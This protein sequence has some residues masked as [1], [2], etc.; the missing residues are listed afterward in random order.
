MGFPPVPPMIK[1]I[2]HILKV[3]DEHDSRD[4]VVS[5]WGKKKS[6]FCCLSH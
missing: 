2:A 6:H 5:Y 3:A 1:S 4:I